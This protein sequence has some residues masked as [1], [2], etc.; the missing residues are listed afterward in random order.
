MFQLPLI[1]VFL[2]K[3][4]AV[5]VE[6]YRKGRRIA[7]FVG[8]ILAVILTPP[9]PFS[10]SLMAIPILFLYE[11]GIVACRLFGKKLAAPEVA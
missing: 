7:I 4:G 2:A 6:T 9:D 8:V 10:W 3:I 1:M 5:T 11:V